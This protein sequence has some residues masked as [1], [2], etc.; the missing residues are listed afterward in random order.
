MARRRDQPS[1]SAPSD[2]RTLDDLGATP[3]EVAE[4]LEWRFGGEGSGLQS[5]GAE[6]RARALARQ[7]R[8]D[9]PDQFTGAV[10]IAGQ[11]G[12][13][14]RP[15]GELLHHDLGWKRASFGGYVRKVAAE[16]QLPEHRAELQRLGAQLIEE[17]G[18][19]GFAEDVLRDANIRPGEEP[20]IIDGVRHV[21][22]YR[23]LKNMF[24][25]LR[26]VYLDTPD[27]SRRSRIKKEEG[28]RVGLW[29]IQEIE[30]HSTEHDLDE[31]RKEAD[32]IVAGHDLAVAHLE[33]L[34]ALDQMVRA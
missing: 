17:R 15:L 12:A 8:L 13:Q 6:L 22:I 33:A 31:L 20:A 18:F 5:Q 2:R 1:S 16:R 4:A 24:D 28:I 30:H 11:V 26:L 23:A 10:A 7:L 25:P 14:K 29:K 32:V 19:E 3:E 27:R 34:R 21:G 9:L